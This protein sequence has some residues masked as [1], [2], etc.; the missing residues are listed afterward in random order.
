MTAKINKRLVIGSIVD[1]NNFDPAAIRIFPQGTKAQFRQFRGFVIRQK[2][3]KHRFF[4][5]SVEFSCVS[6]FPPAD[7]NEKH[8]LKKIHLTGKNT[9]AETKF[10][11]EN[12][13]RQKR[14]FPGGRPVVSA[15]TR[16]KYDAEENPHREAISEMERRVSFRYSSAD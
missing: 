4:P 1:R 16:E 8:G 3:R 12:T 2:N 15:T 11:N 7:T 9:S 6:V 13:V 14:S 5:H 10:R